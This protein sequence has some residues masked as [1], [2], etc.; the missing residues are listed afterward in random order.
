MTVDVGRTSWVTKRFIGTKWNQARGDNR[1]YMLNSYRVLL[2]RARK[3][4]VIWVPSPDGSDPTLDP[5]A[6]D[7]TAAFLSDVGIPPITD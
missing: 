6:L 5:I 2:T 4:M 1:K 7:R 3:G